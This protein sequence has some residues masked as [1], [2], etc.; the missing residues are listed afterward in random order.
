MLAAMLG[1]F[2]KGE[3]AKA[4]LSCSK[5]NGT[6]VHRTGKVVG[7][8]NRDIVKRITY[9]YLYG[10]SDRKLSQILREGN[11]PNHNGKV[12]RERMNKGIV[13]L[14]T[15][16]EILKKKVDPRISYRN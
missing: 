10:A 16:Q 1:H 12:I 6:D 3:Y 13:G 14:G 7:I 9:A 11:A 4:L 2:D 15:L 5:E 8:D